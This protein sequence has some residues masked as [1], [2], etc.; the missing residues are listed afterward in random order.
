MER[1]AK[2]TALVIAGASLILLRR[3]GLMQELAEQAQTQ[4][5]L[6]VGRG[7]FSLLLERLSAFAS[8]S[9]QVALA[10]GA[11]V[12][13]GLELAEGLGL[14][15]RRRWAEYLTVLATSFF[16][17][18]ELAAVLRHATPLRVGALLLNAA[19]VVYLAWR[20]RLFVG[21]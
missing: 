7:L 15:L 8:Y 2:A 5:N 10:L 21:V 17:P 4:L 19:V 18:F 11:F 12:Y 13:A 1:L 16:L 14:A 20:K 6:G 9:H 3:L